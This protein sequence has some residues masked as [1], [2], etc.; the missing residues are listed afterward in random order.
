[1]LDRQQDFGA[2]IGRVLLSA[3]FIWSG[4]WKLLTPAATQAMLGSMGLPLPEIA[5]IVV[6]IIELA[7][8][9]ALL[10]GLL[11]Q[12]V[13]LVLGLWCIATAIAVHTNFGDINMKIHF[14]KNLAMAGGFAYVAVYGAG[15]Y[16]L[17]AMIGA[18]RRSA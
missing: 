18:R 17:D 15:R 16:S 14:M 6:V 11:T 10:V 8:G 13:G 5:W 4:Y 12:P 3:I 9:L 2:L 1:M 7:G